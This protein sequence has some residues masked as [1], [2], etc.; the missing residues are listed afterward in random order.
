MNNWGSIIK[1]RT[2]SGGNFQAALLDA[3][4][5]A[6]RYYQIGIVAMYVPI[7]YWSKKEGH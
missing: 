3:C 6:D 1:I 2:V 7:I 5:I 4:L